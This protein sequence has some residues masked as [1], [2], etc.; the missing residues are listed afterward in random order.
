[1]M[2]NLYQAYV[3]L[4]YNDTSPSNKNI[5]QY[6]KDNSWLIFLGNKESY[7]SVCLILMLNPFLMY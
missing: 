7:V 3:K 6:L 2:K 5:S 1:M 4:F